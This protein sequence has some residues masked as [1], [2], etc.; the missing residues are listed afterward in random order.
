MKSLFEEASARFE[1]QVCGTC[2]RGEGG[3]YLNEEEIDRIAEFL[4]GSREIFLEIYCRIR[5][6]RTYIHIREEDGYCHFA[7]DGKCTIH[8]VKPTPCR[9]WP[10][11]QPML[12]DQANWDVAR[13][14]CPALAPFK[15]L[16]DYL[17]GIRSE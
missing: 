7:V 15:T 2:C 3:I 14:S 13:H 11:F 16:E 10:F 5:N 1:C 12:A 9:Q 4:G 6:G 17:K 8:S